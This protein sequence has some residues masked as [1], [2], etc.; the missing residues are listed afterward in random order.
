MVKEKEKRNIKPSH[1]LI[2]PFTNNLNTPLTEPSRL[3]ASIPLPFSSLV[4]ETPSKVS[5]DKFD[6]WYKDGLR[7]N[8]R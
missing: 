5:Q 8:W 6:V 1:F 4:D 2:S 7:A 3:V